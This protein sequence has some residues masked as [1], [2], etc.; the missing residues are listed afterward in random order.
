MRISSAALQN[1]VHTR[2]FSL[3][4]SQTRRCRGAC[5]TGQCALLATY[6]IPTQSLVDKLDCYS[7][8]AKNGKAAKGRANQGY[9]SA[10]WRKRSQRFAVAESLHVNGSNE[11][12]LVFLLRWRDGHGEAEHLGTEVRDLQKK[13]TASCQC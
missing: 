1:P 8:P 6:T 4:L 5:C 3:S 2:G 12:D 9:P 11:E 13:T 7:R 10:I